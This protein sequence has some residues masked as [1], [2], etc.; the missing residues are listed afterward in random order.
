MSN[1]TGVGVGVGVGVGDGAGTVE[2]SFEHA[3]RNIIAASAHQI[4]EYFL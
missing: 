2:S 3:T 1:G 4:I